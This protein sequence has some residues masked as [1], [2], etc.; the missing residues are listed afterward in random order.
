MISTR[1]SSKLCR[2][3]W[4]FTYGQEQTVEESALRRQ[5]LASSQRESDTAAERSMT[6]QIVFTEKAATPPATYSQAVKAAGLVFVSGDI[7]CRCC[8]GCHHRQHHSGTDPPV[9]D[10]R[11]GDSRGGW[12]FIGK[13]SQLHRR[14]SGRRRL[15]RHERGVAAMVP[16]RSS[17]QAGSKVACANSRPQDFHRG[18]R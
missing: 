10:Q 6:R 5:L 16:V 2:L 15:C 11:A 14:P 18:N 9:S 1:E 4:R 8:H 3:W 13:G 7:A 17:C 12:Q